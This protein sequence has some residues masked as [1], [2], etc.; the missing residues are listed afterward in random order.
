MA[1]VKEPKAVTKF[2]ASCGKDIND[3][4]AADMDRTT[5]KDFVMNR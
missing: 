4:V 3:I 5:K 2:L 1:N